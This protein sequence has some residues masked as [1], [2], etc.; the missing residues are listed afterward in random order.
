MR[1]IAA[2]LILFFIPFIAYAKPDVPEYE[3]TI[4]KGKIFF[5]NSEYAKALE[6]FN[7]A[8]SAKPED[9]AANWWLGVSYL[10]AGNHEKA[11]APLT[12]AARDPEL[13]VTANYYLGIAYYRLG[14]FDDAKKS[15]ESVLAHSPPEDLKSYAHEYLADIN[16]QP[17]KQRDISALSYKSAKPWELTFAAGIQYDTNAILAPDDEKL[18]SAMG[19]KKGSNDWRSVLY[20]DGTYN[21]IDK[22]NWLSGVG[23]SVYQN[24]HKRHSSYNTNVQSLSA[25]SVYSKDPFS[26]KA[27]Y[28]YEYTLF[29]GHRF[30]SVHALSSKLSVI[31]CPHTF[32]ELTYA[33]HKNYYWDSHLSTTNSDRR[34]HNHSIGI[35]Q[36][37]RISNAIRLTAG[38]NRD[39][40]SAIR[41][42]WSYKGD[43]FS[44]SIDA[45]KNPWRFNLGADTYNRKYKEQDPVAAIIR[46]DRTYTYSAGITRALSQRMDV[47]LMYDFVHSNSNIESF[48]YKREISSIFA[49]IRF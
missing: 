36:I 46:A 8:V 30:S 27:E 1:L 40:E 15:F 6:E 35:S 33:Y 43:K 38:Y 37:V 5:N 16:K 31:E 29:G 26:V 9:P 25:F 17:A 12:K 23:Y 10:K 24:L 22:E 20:L 42:Y 39:V 34:G 44:V 3:V 13:S 28:D 11:T 41:D 49:T 14:F 47:I 7:S 21:L 45:V 19:I 32:S 4:E 48:A 2:I 18:V